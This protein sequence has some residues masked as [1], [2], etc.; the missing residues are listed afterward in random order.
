VEI[1][2]LATFLIMGLSILTPPFAV[3]RSVS[4]Q[5]SGMRTLL[6]RA[7]ALL[8]PL[9]VAYC[10]LVLLWLPGFNGQCG[11]WLGETSPCGFRQFAGETMFWAAM[12]LA[13]PGILG[14]VL[15]LVVLA[16]LSIRRY[17]SRPSTRK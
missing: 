5:T 8:G 15:G 1:M 4:R 10:L 11:G 16:G 6:G 3:W 2:I 12:T 7:L 17:A 14:V 13:V 9:A